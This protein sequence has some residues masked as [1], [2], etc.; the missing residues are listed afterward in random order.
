MYISV[1]CRKGVN[2]L[3]RSIKIFYPSPETSLKWKNY[4]VGFKLGKKS[5]SSN[6]IFQTGEFEKS[7][8]NR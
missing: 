1:N 5:S 6:S 3:A 2:S 7:S 4:P 8:S